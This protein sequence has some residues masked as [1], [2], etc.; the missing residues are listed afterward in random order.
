M[1][2]CSLGAASKDQIVSYDQETNAIY[3][4]YSYSQDISD[5]VLHTKTMVK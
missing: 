5:E 1:V 2:W 3:D 4:T